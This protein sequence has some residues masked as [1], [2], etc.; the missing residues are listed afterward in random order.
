[1]TEPVRLTL[2]DR[3]HIAGT[4]ANARFFGKSSPLL[5]G[6]SLTDRCQFRCSYCGICGT[7]EHDLPTPRVVEVI[8][9]LRDMGC[10]RIQYTGGE[11]LLRDDIGDI[12]TATRLAGI[13]ATISTNGMAVPKK[14]DDLVGVAAVNISLDGPEPVH[15]AVRGKGAFAGVTRAI[16]AAKKAGI[17]I[18]FAAVL[19]KG[20]LEHVEFLVEFAASHGTLITFQPVTRE[21]L[22]TPEDNPLVPETEDYRRAIDRLIALQEK[23]APVGNSIPA[24]QHLR[25]WPGPAPILCVGGRI[26]LR[27]EADGSV[28]NCQRRGGEPDG[29]LESGNIYENLRAV[30]AVGCSTCWSAPVVEAACVLEGKVRSMLHLNRIL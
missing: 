7:G 5:V 23:G 11:P 25:K 14:L 10:R 2:L 16:D 21:V 4:V 1:M 29:H 19:H 20:N 3:I 18:R 6:W 22:G 13:S 8:A 26:F 15:D 30:H 28:V 27:I 9:A 24:L 12:L 17:P